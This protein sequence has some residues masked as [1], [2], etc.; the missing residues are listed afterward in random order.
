MS[1]ALTREEWNEKSNT[2]KV[3]VNYEDLH[4]RGLNDSCRRIDQK[5]SGD[6]RKDVVLN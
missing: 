2:S 1:M 5:L 4:V 3:R 6:M